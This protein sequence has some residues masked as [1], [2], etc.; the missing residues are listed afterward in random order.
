[1]IRRILTIMWGDEQGTALVEATL[2]TPVVLAL[3]L[4]V[5][6]FAWYFYQQQAIEVGLR[7]AARYIARIAPSSDPT[8]SSGDWPSAQYLA[9]TGS[10]DTTN[11]NQRVRGWTPGQVNFTCLA[12]PNT[13]GYLG[14]DGTNIYVV[15]A[16]TNFT[17]LSLGF[18]GY[19]G[20][21]PKTIPISHQE[22]TIGRFF[23]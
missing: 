10:V 19:L 11:T 17:A 14:G 1:M 3:V 18:L 16:S 5:F 9:T 21:N 20:V 7:D 12:L 8:C 15:Q 22:R 4:G 6:E 13:G 2:L 23:P